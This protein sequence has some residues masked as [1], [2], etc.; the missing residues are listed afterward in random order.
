MICFVPQIFYRYYGGEFDFILV[1][2]FAP[3]DDSERAITMACVAFQYSSDSHL[4]CANVVGS[5]SPNSRDPSDH[6]LA[7]ARGPREHQFDGRT[8]FQ[9]YL[10]VICLL[11]Q[12]LRLDELHTTLFN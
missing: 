8:A 2:G 10:V 1:L 4:S 5:S 3:T 6:I 12:V 11:I 9:D 7:R